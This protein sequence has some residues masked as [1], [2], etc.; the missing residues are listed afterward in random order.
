M[1]NNV[2]VAVPS[3]VL[4]AGPAAAFQEELRL[5]AFVNAYVDGNSDRYALALNPRKFFRMTRKLT[6]TDYQTLWSFYQA[7]IITPFYF[8]NPYE[9]A[10]LFTSDPTGT[11]TTGRYVVVFDGSWSDALQIGRSQASFGL[12]EVA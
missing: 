10:P 6:S 3:G 9:T 5:E 7:H 2:H 4:P 11:A 1:P 12:R 8:Y